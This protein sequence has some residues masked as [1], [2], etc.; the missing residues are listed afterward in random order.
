MTA[1]PF[2][3]TSAPGRRPHSGAGRLLNC[4]AEPLVNGARSQYVWRRAP[5]LRPFATSASFSGNRGQFGVGSNLFSA[6]SGKISRFNSAGAET[7]VG[8]FAGTKK[9]FWAANNASTPNI[10]VVDPDNGASI[11]TTSSVTSYPDPDLPAVNSV[12]AL[13][14][15]LFFTTGDGKCFAS[16]LN[17]T[18]IDALD[19]VGAQAKRDGL[20]RAVAYGDLYLCGQDSIEVYHDTAESTGFPFS[21]AQVIPKG[22]ASPYGL[23]GHE[24]FFSKGIVFLGADLRVYAL[25]GYTPVAISTSDVDRA[26]T[27]FKEAGGDVTTI[28]MFS[29]TVAGRSCIVMRC[30]AWTWVFDV[31]LKWWHERKSYGKEYWRATGAVYHFNKWLAGDTES[32]KIVE[33]TAAVGNELGNSIPFQIE[34]GPVSAFPNNVACA[35]ATFDIARGVGIATGTDPTQ[36]D[37]RVEISYSPDGGVNWSYPRI[38]KLGAQAESPRSP[39]RVSKCGL[40]KHSG[41]R[42]RLVVT[43]DVDVEFTGG[44]MLGEARHG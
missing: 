38:R 25:D 6:F 37:P 24:D 17:A 23:T 7:V 3:L 12:C 11:V 9:V 36:T 19:F 28:E 35:M 39:V 29:Y 20:M 22:L 16:G 21:R 43:D 26:V 41:F 32:G 40:S 42:W 13:D 44:D 10:V 15:Y 14:G 5:G 18:S 30:P 2:P 1:I 34:S 33:I 27:D 31:D 8:N 4:Y